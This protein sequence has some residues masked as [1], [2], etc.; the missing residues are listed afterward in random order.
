MS[1]RITFRKMETLTVPQILQMDSPPIQKD[2]DEIGL[3]Y[4]NTLVSYI[5]FKL[6][7]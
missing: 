7:C 2:D 6:F 1:D 4:Q 5:F 3:G